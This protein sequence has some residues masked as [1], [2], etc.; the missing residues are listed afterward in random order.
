LLLRMTCIEYLIRNGKMNNQY[1]VKT[2]YTNMIIVNSVWQ[3][4]S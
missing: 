2:S 4:R 1:F 3:N